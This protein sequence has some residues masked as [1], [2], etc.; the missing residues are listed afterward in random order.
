VF[1]DAGEWPLEQYPYFT[2]FQPKT[3]EL[4]ETT[5]ETGEHVAQTAE[6]LS[7]QLNNYRLTPVGS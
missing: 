2:D 4:V 5:T 6:P 3:R 1:P 7:F